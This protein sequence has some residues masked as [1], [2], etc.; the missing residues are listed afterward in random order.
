ML[1]NWMDRQMDGWLDVSPALL[2]AG[3][4]CFG[5]CSREMGVGFNLGLILYLSGSGHKT[6][7][8]VL[9]GTW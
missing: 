6:R 4:F 1:L 7:G 5:Q 9:M 8:C 2:Q 3:S